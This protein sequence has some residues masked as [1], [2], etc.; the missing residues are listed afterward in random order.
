MFLSKYHHKTALKNSNSDAKTLTFHTYNHNCQIITLKDSRNKNLNRFPWLLC[1]TSR[2]KKAFSFWGRRASPPRPPDQGLCLWTPLG[3]P[4]SDPRYR[5]ALHMLAMVF[6]PPL[7]FTFRGPCTL[8][9]TKN[10]GKNL[11]IKQKNGKSQK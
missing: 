10:N 4:P 2:N 6:D 9:E 5:L 7:F 1:V 8:L 11:K 3:A